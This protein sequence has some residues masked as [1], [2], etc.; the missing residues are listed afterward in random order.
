VMMATTPGCCTRS[1]MR[2]WNR[3]LR[4]RL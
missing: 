1:S 3:Q 2:N 4:C